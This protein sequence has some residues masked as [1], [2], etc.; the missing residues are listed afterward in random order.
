MPY[1]RKDTLGDHALPLPGL[2]EENIVQ[3]GTGIDRE[4][5]D[6]LEE[7]DIPVIAV[8]EITTLDYEEQQRKAQQTASTASPVG[9][10]FYRPPLQTPPPLRTLRKWDTMQLVELG[11][12]RLQNEGLHSRGRERDPVSISEEPAKVSVTSSL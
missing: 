11:S 8:D 9:N 12:S 7:V 1:P 4:D 10:A 6:G 2:S 5:R 3:M